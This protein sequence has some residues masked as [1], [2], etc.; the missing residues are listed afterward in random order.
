MDNH[1]K[2][3]PYLQ[4]LAQE[5]AVDLRPGDVMS[6]EEKGYLCRQQLL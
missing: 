6:Q 1:P 4:Q 3:L 5:Q 2:P